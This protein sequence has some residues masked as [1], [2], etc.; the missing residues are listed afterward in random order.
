MIE[1]AHAEIT[2]RKFYLAHS[3]V[4]RKNA[5]TTKLRV[6]YDASAHTNGN[7]LSLND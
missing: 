2:G 5:E 3:A 7:A 4:V 1:L 6:V